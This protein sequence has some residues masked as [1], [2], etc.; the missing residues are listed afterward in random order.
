MATG[1]TNKFAYD[2]KYYES[3]YSKA[4]EGNAARQLAQEEYEEEYYSDEELYEEDYES[5]DFYGVEPEYIPD[6][7]VYEEAE[8]QVRYK[9]KYHVNLV[10]T[11][12]LVITLGALLLHAY[13]YLSVQSQINM[14]TN[15]L[16]SAKN[17]LTDIQ[18]MNASL[19]TQ[20]D[21]DVDRNMIYSIAVSKF[22]MQ[23]PN[24]N[25][26]IYYDSPDSGH[27][28]QFQ[29]IPGVM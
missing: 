11:M 29:K 26:T 25:Q 10:T 28:R 3:R 17:E 8:V 7:E 23:Y 21:V 6:N 2:R 9:T 14:L 19:K 1:R 24:E 20:L 18:S 13:R 27:V 16:Q 12:F 15:E 22:N 5:E 4:V